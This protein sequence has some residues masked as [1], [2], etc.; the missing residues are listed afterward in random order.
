MADPALSV[1]PQSSIQELILGEPPD[2][3]PGE[4]HSPGVPTIPST[5]QLIPVPR[6]RAVWHISP[7]RGGSQPHLVRCS[8]RR[9]YVLKLINNPQGKRILA[10]ELLSYHLASLLGLPVVPCAI[11]EIDKFTVELN[12][13]MAIHWRDR[14]N[15]CEPGLVFGSRYEPPFLMPRQPGK[16][17]DENAIPA[18]LMRFVENRSDF[19]GMLVFD[20]WVSNLDH[21]QVLYASRMKGR[22]FRVYMIDN[23]L[24]F[25]GT[26]WDLPYHASSNLYH[27][28]SVYDGIEKIE[29]FEPWLTR[30]ECAIQRPALEAIAAAVPREWCVGECGQLLGLIEKL[31]Q[32]RELVRGQIIARYFAQG[33]FRG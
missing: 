1:L 23:G 14:T 4:D 31:E 12:P 24:S 27:N 28:R 21:R 30:L 9:F 7:I 17:L 18:C 26:R 32:R 16:S 22:N 20:T 15:P 10:N 33:R 29:D 5:P 19:R 11:V 3:V 13:G 25:C 8:D 6:V 2:R